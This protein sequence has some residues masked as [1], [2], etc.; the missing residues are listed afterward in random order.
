M[1][2]HAPSPALPEEGGC[3]CGVVVWAKL[4]AA[5]NPRQHLVVGELTRV[6]GRAHVPLSLL[7]QQLQDL[8]VSGKGE[9]RFG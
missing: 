9:G 8:G 6:A 3:V 5:L 4:Q 2:I 1:P 7:V